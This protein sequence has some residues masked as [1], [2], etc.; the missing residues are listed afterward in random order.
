[1][2]FLGGF[3]LRIAIITSPGPWAEFCRKTVHGQEDVLVLETEGDPTRVFPELRQQ[4]VAVLVARGNWATLLRR[5]IRLPVVAVEPTAFDLIAAVLAARKISKKA[6]IIYFSGEEPDWQS[7]WEAL[8]LE[9]KLVKVARNLADVRWTVANLAR[10]RVGVIVGG[11]VTVAVAEEFGLPGIVVQPGREALLAALDIGREL[12]RTTGGATPG[13]LASFELPPEVEEVA[14][15]A[16]AAG[17]AKMISSQAE[18]QLPAPE[19]ATPEGASGQGPTP[20][21]DVAEEAEVSLSPA[22]RE[23]RALLEEAARSE[24][25]LV[26]FGERGTGK[27]F[28]AEFVHRSSRRRDGPWVKFVGGLDAEE[29]FWAKENGIWARAAGG[30]L[31]LEGL[32]RTAAEFQERLALVLEREEQDRQPFVQGAMETGERKRRRVIAL[33]REDPRTL[34]GKGLLPDLLDRIGGL[35]VRIPA[36]RERREDIPALLKKLLA[37][38]GRGDLSP[39]ALAVLLNHSW[40]GNVREL[41]AFAN[42]LVFLSRA[43]PNLPAAALEKR[44]AD[45][46]LQGGSEERLLE[47]SV[48]P[49]RL[50]DMEREIIRKMQRVLPGS[51]S[52]LARRLGVSRTTLW[53]KLK[54]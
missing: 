45:D 1:M 54:S 4:D 35:F 24:L 52:E 20:A 44:A 30:S 53:K 9:V 2:T 34:L 11:N 40:P 6:G 22:G 7:L 43:L 47:I 42:H 3:W 41:E 27:D 5:T 23:L 12:L 49:G 21:T 14:V 37:A 19:A 39:E 16:A 50:E 33:F 48:T 38:R 25:P 36:L 10:Q 17:E 26:L 46:W 18:D 15:E 28:W 13:F 51:K 29:E 32:E 8:G 31:V